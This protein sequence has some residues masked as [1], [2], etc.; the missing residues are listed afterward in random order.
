MTHQQGESMTQAEIGARDFLARIKE[1]KKDCKDG[2]ESA[3][4]RKEI[5][6]LLM[7]L[8]RLAAEKSYSPYSRFPVGAALVTS[9]G[10]VFTGCNVENAS[11]GGAI[12]AERTAIV[13][14]VSE[15]FTDIEIIAVYCQKA[16]DAWPCG[17][18]R[19]FISEFGA[20]IEII[21]ESLDGNIRSVKISDLLPHMFGPGAF[22]GKD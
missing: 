14:A 8:S 10:H 15:G 12:C 13:K 19:Q 4:V 2:T 3:A 1:L 9:S 20:N 7:A 18:C 16:R 5:H 11:Y 21:S 17:I 22:L 6:E